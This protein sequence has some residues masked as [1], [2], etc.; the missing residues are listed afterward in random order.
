VIKTEIE[1]LENMEEYTH[2][3]LEEEKTNWIFKKEEFLENKE[4]LLKEAKAVYLAKKI[5]K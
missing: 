2:I 1:K 3:I 5:S 4:K